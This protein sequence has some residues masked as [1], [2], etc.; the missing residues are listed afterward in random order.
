MA[1]L[2]ILIYIFGIAF[3]S[4]L[5]D[6]DVGK[7]SFPRVLYSMHSLLMHGAFC[8]DLTGIMTELIKESYIALTLMYILILL[9][10]VTVMNMLIGI[11]CEVIT[12]VADAEREAIQLGFVKET[13]Q[14]CLAAGVDKNDDGLIDQEEFLAML[15]NQDAIEALTEIDVDVVSIY[16]YIHVLFEEGQD[17]NM[18]FPEFI[19]MLLKLR[20]GNAATV[21]DLVDLRKWLVGKMNDMEE[22][23]K[24]I[25]SPPLV[26]SAPPPRPRSRPD[27]QTVTC[28]PASRPTDTMPLLPGKPDQQTENGDS[29]SRQ[30]GALPLLPGKPDLQTATGDSAN[31]QT[32]ALPLLPGKP[33]QQ[34]ATID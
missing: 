32:D 18:P 25:G 1:L 24:T 30:I 8:D 27:K 4:I 23:V 12:A 9:A 14:R 10:A 31:Q 13:L 33:D 3:T 17:S 11:L 28:N 26:L 2:M 21:K 20:G 22:L 34:M 15:Q 5:K 6:S 19:D 16:D 29:A 7:A